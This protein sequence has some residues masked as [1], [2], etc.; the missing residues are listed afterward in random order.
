MVDRIRVLQFGRYFPP[1]IGGTENVMF[2]LFEGLNKKGI[3]TDVLCCNDYNQYEESNFGEAKVLRT[4]TFFKFGSIAF[5]PQQILVLRRIWKQYDIIHV[6]HPAPMATVALWL[7]KPS[8]K[9][10]IYWHSDIVRQRLLLLFF[11]PLQNWL[12]KRSDSIVATTPNYI[13]A[14]ESL[15]KYPPKTSY[16]PIGIS[17]LPITNEEKL[18][19]LQKQYHEKKIV[20]SLGRLVGYKGFKYLIDAAKYLDDTY[21]ILIGGAGPLR[22]SLEDQILKNNLQAKVKLLGRLSD[23]D[24]PIFFQLCDV[25]CMSSI[26]KNEAFGLVLAEAM[27]FSKPI[28]ATN[29]PGSGVP[30]LNEN[31]VSGLNVE[32]KNP[33][34]IALAI[35]EILE[36][37]ERK[38][39]LSNG[40]L[41]RFSKYFKKEMMVDSYIALYKKIVNYKVK[42]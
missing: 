4:K 22:A 35:K 26:T 24:L 19:N 30:W 17:T 31:S 34:A 25:Y 23:E 5:S 18:K 41:N 20:F 10:V 7:I 16:I 14:S 32:I 27:S 21:V 13:K 37:D 3:A 1:H 6:H 33:E 8:C 15:Q 11:K 9:I 36:N 38:K 40:A 39:S 42:G 29:I 12:L 28:V 2:D